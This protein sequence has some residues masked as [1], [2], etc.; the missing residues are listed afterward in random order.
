MK[1]KQV[2]LCQLCESTALL[3]LLP[4]ASVSWKS[5]GYNARRSTKG[6]STFLAHRSNCSLNYWRNIVQVLKKT[7]TDWLLF[8]ITSQ[9]HSMWFAG[10]KN[11]ESHSSSWILLKRPFWSWN[12]KAN[13]SRSDLARPLQV[14]IS[15]VSV[16]FIYLFFT[17]HYFDGTL[18]D[19]NLPCY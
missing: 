13:L 11:F 1:L 7:K 6:R 2:Q 9:V 19:T 17:Y 10:V 8:Y 4:S 16:S 18:Y 15:N 12:S 3:A 14:F 5:F